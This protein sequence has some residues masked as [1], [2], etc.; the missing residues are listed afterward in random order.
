M[1]EEVDTYH[2]SKNNMTVAE[3]KRPYTYMTFVVQLQFGK[4]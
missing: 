3:L 2:C 4:I 1:T